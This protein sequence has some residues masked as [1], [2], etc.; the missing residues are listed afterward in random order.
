MEISDQLAAYDDYWRKFGA[1]IAGG[2]GAGEFSESESQVVCATIVARLP[3]A[4][5]TALVDVL[6]PLRKKF[7]GH[8]FYPADTI[9]LTLID[10]S[11]LVD[12]GDFSRIPVSAV[13][14]FSIL[15]EELR[16]EPPLELRLQGLGLFPTTV[17]G[18]LL[19]LKGRITYLRERVGELL[20]RETGVVLRP[21]VVPGLVFSNV[22]RYTAVPSAGV[23]DEVGACREAP[24]LSFEVA[25]FEVVTTDKVLS[26][27]HTTVHGRLKLAG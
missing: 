21:A 11:P 17:F 7:P 18:Q 25:N 16:D 12:F 23:V 27:R 9:H 2:G 22:V 5:A 10:V 8:Y 1:Q 24:R 26:R 4:V 3:A 6:G 14:A 19:D 13:K 15:E 20:R